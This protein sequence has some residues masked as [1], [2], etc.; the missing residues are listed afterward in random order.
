M[1]IRLGVAEFKQYAVG[2]VLPQWYL[3]CR[4]MSGDQAQCYLRHHL[5]TGQA[6]TELLLRH[7]QQINCRLHIGY[8]RPSGALRSRLGKQFHGGRGDDAQG[9]FAAYE[10]MPQ[11]VTRVVF[12]HAA[13]ARHYVALRG[14]HFQAQAQVACI[15]VT[16]H[17]RAASVTR[18]VAAQCATAFRCQA[19]CKQKTGL[20]GGL[21]YLLKNATGI[22]GEGGVGWVNVAHLVHA[23]Q[24]DDHFA[25]RGVWR[26]AH[27]QTRVAALRHH[28]RTGSRT[29][30]HYGR[31]FGSCPRAHHT[32]CLS[33]FA[34][35]P[36]ALVR[37]QAVTCQH[38]D[39]T[40][41]Q[42][43]AVNQSVHA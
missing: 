30:F 11:V 8:C 41:D 33:V 1:R 7:A 32:Q 22:S 14:H 20:V 24:V 15:A 17:L 16:Q 12:A 28:R 31:H 43:Q 40:A 25:T 35:A 38:V 21:L 4:E 39:I 34:A 23:L 10:Q 3:Q 36:V 29:D 26:G 37:S 6:C 9:S 27:H 2:R 5:E 13:Q 42:A 18:Q 19:E